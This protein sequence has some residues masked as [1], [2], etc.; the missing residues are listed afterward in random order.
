MPYINGIWFG[1]PGVQTVVNDSSF[2]GAPNVGGLGV[3]LVGPSTDGEPNTILGPFASP[4]A[5]M[6]Q[7]KGGDLLQ[8]VLNAFAGASKAGGTSPVS[9]SAINVNSLTPATSAIKSAGGTTQIALTTV[10]YGNPA[11]ADKWMIQAG[12]TVGYKVSQASDYIGPGTQTYAPNTTDN[13]ALAALTLAYTGSDTAPL[14]SVTDTSFEVTATANAASVTLANI[15]LSSTVTVQQ[16]VNQLNAISGLVATVA[17]PNANDVTGA[18]FDNVSNV[19]VSTSSSAPTTLYANVTAVTR[20]F[21]G[22]GL[23]FTAVR[24]AAATSIATAPTWTYAAGATAP[25]A[26]NT[27]WQNAY[28]T[29]QSATGIM[30]VTP[31]SSASSIWAMNDAHCQYMA[32]IGIP[33]R[34]YVGDASG[35]T[36]AQEIT[37][38]GQ[39]NSSRTTLVW[40]EQAGT[41]YNG[42]PTTFAPYLE[43]CAIVGERAATVPYNALTQ[44]PVPS[45]GMGQIVTPGMVAQALQNNIAILAPNQ[46]GVVVMQ[47]DMTTWGQTTAY[48]KVENSTGLVVDIVTQDLNA[49]LQQ[50]IGKP[51]PLGVAASAVL[52]RLNYWYHQGYIL[53]QPKA[54]DVQL[55][56]PAA[57]QIAGSAQA[58]FAVPTNYIG[59]QLV[60][61]AVAA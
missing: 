20:Y 24:Q 54:S 28:T 50:F 9:V 51:T 14:V 10:Q 40:P 48:D 30:F 36:L 53:T 32:S 11:N 25:A 2:Q 42:N 55:T 57:D 18:F 35:Q 27:N 6:A 21:N 4:S 8:G 46:A 39:L 31:V 23:Y 34:G 13:V 59:L 61:V 44:Q 47:H 29:A 17:D 7:L 41:D 16:L 33:R 5:A 52:S 37:N 26:S 38:S 3:L 60:P 58:A 19:A 12:S 45:A 22:L 1:A 43:A 49:T 56:N 15:A